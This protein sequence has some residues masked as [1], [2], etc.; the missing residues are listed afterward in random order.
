[1]PPPAATW[2]PNDLSYFAVGS[3]D[4]LSRDVRI[5]GASDGQRGPSIVAELGRMLAPPVRNGEGS[6]MQR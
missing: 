5:R 2:Q 4:R 6:G 3:M 1:L